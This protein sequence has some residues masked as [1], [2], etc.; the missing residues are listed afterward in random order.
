MFY[1]PNKMMSHTSVVTGEDIR[2]DLARI[3]YQG[4]AGHIFGTG[5]WT[6]PRNAFDKLCKLLDRRELDKFIREGAKKAGLKIK[7]I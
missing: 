1:A 5:A 4:V 3:I 7:R 6:E 2:Y